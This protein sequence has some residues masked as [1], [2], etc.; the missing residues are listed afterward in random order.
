MHEVP[1][2]A[3]IPDGGQFSSRL[4]LLRH[5][6]G[7]NAKE[8]A[9][10]CTIAPQSWREWEDGRMPRDYAGSCRKIAERTGCDEV[11]L[12]TGFQKPDVPVLLPRTNDADQDGDQVSERSS[13]RSGQEAPRERHLEVVR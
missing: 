13:V 8:A 3:W 1:G 5:A 10:A 11:W 9:L 12:M 4:A 6:M 7:W 2:P